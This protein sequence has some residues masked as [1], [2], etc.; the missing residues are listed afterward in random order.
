[1]GLYC[2][3]PHRFHGYLPEFFR[4]RSIWPDRTINLI[5]GFFVLKVKENLSTHFCPSTAPV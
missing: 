1:M 3:P 2:H 4:N 5:I